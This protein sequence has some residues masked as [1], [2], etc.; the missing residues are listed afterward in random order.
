MLSQENLIREMEENP[1]DNYVRELGAIEAKMVAG[2]SGVGRYTYTEDDTDYIQGYAPIPRHGRL[3]RG[4]DY[5]R[6]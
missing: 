5:Q 1:G 6:G 2:E 3:E 4:R